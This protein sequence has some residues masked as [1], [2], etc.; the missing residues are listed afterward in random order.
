MVLAAL[1]LCQ[2]PCWLQGTGTGLRYR[3]GGRKLRLAIDLKKHDT[4][5]I[6]LVAM[7]VNDLI[8]QGARPSSSS[9]TM[10]PANW[11]V[12]TAAAVVTGIPAPAANS[13]AVPW[14]A[15]SCRNAWHV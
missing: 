1:G 5:G 3:R 2:N 10:P 7:C 11:T 9:T 15:V 6:D 13:P 12:D 14:S 8:V 4:V